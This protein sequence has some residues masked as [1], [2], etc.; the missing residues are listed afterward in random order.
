MIHT[1]NKTTYPKAEELRDLS[2]S[3]KQFRKINDNLS[4]VAISN[5]ELIALNRNE[6]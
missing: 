2:I 6:I 1:N 3:N 5:T 4:D